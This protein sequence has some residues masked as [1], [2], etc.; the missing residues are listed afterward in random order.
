MLKYW[1]LALGCATFATAAHADEAAKESLIE[2]LEQTATLTADFRQETYGDGEL[3]GDQASG[4]MYIER[5]L[6]FA[7]IVEQPYEQK[8][9]SD[10]DM[11]WIYDPDLDQ[12]TYQPV[13]EQILQSPAMILAQPKTALAQSYEVTRATND[14]LTAYRLFP[15]HPDAVFSDMTLLFEDGVIQEIRLSDNLGQDTRITLSNVKTG[16]DIDASRFKFEPPPGTDVF[17]QM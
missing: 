10:G 7:W 12:A 4:R 6:K 11:L 13:R 2:R 5:P 14:D 9:I 1:V 3:R 17:Q 16:V 8:V 15:T